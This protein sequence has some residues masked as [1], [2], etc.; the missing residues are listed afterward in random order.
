MRP[1]IKIPRILKVNRVDRMTASVV[2]NNG[3]S[4]IIDFKTVFNQIGLHEAFP[5]FIL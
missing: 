4:G 3:D 5:A 2:F 1:N